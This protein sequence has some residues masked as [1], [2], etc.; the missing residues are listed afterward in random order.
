MGLW[1][2][3]LDGTGRKRWF[4]YRAVMSIVCQKNGAVTF[5]L[6]DGN[7]FTVNFY[8]SLPAGPDLDQ[9]IMEMQQETTKEIRH[10]GSMESEE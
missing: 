4:P 1:F 8:R 2:E 3:I 5:R 7:D 10:M 9:A 6:K